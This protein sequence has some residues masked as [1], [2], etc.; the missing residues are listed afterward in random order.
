MLK[1]KKSYFIPIIGFAIIIIVGSFLLCLPICNN[2]P[3]EYR[4]A[5]FTAISG[6]TTTGVAKG[7]LIEQYSI[8][9]QII[10]AFMMEVGAL[11]FLVFVSFFWAITN[12]KI[13]ISDIITINDNLSSDNLGLF[14]EYSIFIFK[15]MIRVQIIGMILLAIKFIPEYGLL[16][17][18]WFSVF[19]AISAFA[20]SGFDLL[21]EGGFIKYQ[22][23]IY[24]QV[25]T[26]GI[27][28]LGSVGILTIEDIVSN[29]KNKF[30]MVKAQTKILLVGTLFI[31]AAS[32]ILLKIYEPQ[33]SILNCL[34]ATVASRST[35]FSIVDFE[36]LSI[37]SLLTIIVVMFVGGAPSSTAGGVKILSIAIIIATIIS[38]L[39]GKDETIMF[40]RKI[41]EIVVRRA[42]VILFLFL[43][44]L[45][46]AGI[47][48]YFNSDLSVIE[49]MFD[50]VSCISNTGYSIVD[51]SS[52]NI[53]TDVVMMTLMFVGRVGPLSMVLA[54]VRSA[55]KKKYVKY[56]EENIVLW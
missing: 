15:I 31:I 4:T 11:G 37:K 34:F 1:S 35:G 30:K 16:Q 51:Y 26:I 46:I 2:K 25:V 8:F 23:D 50:S 28:F 55:N 12:K 40:W 29:K 54:F 45:F 36:H 44:I 5:L 49:I 21:G 47:V 10:L 33:M 7:S 52:A 42:F 38:T 53:T 43:L 32:T 18:I 14:K 39:K 6:V 41:P 24:V 13:K 17:G 9:G 3:I 27:M 22:N 20:N 48:L 19:H 56:A